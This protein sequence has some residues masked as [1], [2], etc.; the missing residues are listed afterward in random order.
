VSRPILE[1]SELCVRAMVPGARGDSIEVV[2]NA[3]FALERGQI[4]G[5]LGATGCGKTVLV[6]TLLGISGARPGRVSGD[7]TLWLQDAEAKVSLFQPGAAAKLRPGWAG[8]VFQDP[9]AALDPLRR[10]LDQVTDSVAIRHRDVTRGERRERALEWLNQ[11]RLDDPT[12]VGQL[13]PYE[14]SGGM[15]QRVCVAVALATE[16]ELLVADEPTVGLDWSL[17]REMVELLGEQ[18]G[19][20]GMTLLLI[21]HDIQVVQHLSE[22]VL[23]MEDG[24]IVKQGPYNLVFPPPASHTYTGELEVW[25]DTLD[26]ESALSPREVVEARPRGEV[27][28]KA[29]GLSHSFPAPK[30]GDA[31]VTAVTNVDFEIHEGEF[32]GLV[33]E[34]GSGKTTLGKL[35][36]WILQPDSGEVSFEGKTLGSLDQHALRALRG[37]LQLSYQQPSGALNPGMSVAQHWGET[38]A[39]HRPD[40]TQRSEQLIEETLV[41]YRLE[42]KGPARP[43]ELSGGERR[44]V[45]V[46]RSMLPRPSLLILD[47]PTAG[48][49]AAVKG[50]LIE[51][52]RSSQEKDNACLLIS[53]ELDLVQ[54]VTDRIAVMYAGRIIEEMPAELLDSNAGASD[55]HPYTEQLL[56]ASFRSMRRIVAPNRPDLEPSGCCFRSRCH[57]VEP[58]TDLWEQCTLN[59]PQ[60]VQ[61][62]SGGHKIACHFAEQLSALEP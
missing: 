23:L 13:Y 41:A 36:L 31:P 18:C 54:R 44:R 37:R 27:L 49:D 38:I 52:L 14:L 53:H 35:L 2:R 21:S 12:R 5:L 39:L 7:A 19:Q 43:G 61:L 48:L 45:S 60:L 47:E 25:A 22:H 10:V 32:V 56:S 40:E 4:C 59:E 51:L 16:P 24:E 26:D 29:H 20:H 46:A 8:Y 28:L 42:G 50:Q 3:T 62:G 15:A 17:R 33:G 30:A 34:S 1:V 11:V 57:R 55:L 9:V 58:G 6:R